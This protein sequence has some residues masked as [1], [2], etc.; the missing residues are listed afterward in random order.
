MLIYIPVL[1]QSTF[2][3]LL[4]TLSKLRMKDRKTETP[5]LTPQGESR[6][7]KVCIWSMLPPD[8]S[9]D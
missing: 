8:H 9:I 7:L 5:I 6:Y 2:S 1:V 3:S 4:S